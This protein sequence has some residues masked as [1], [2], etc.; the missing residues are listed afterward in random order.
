MFSGKIWRRRVCYYS[1]WNYH[2]KANQIAEQVR[3]TVEG[4]LLPH[5]LSD[6]FPY[7]TISVGLA[8]LI[9]NSQTSPEYLIANADSALYDAKMAGRNRIC[10]RPVNKEF[11]NLSS[12]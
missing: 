2:K 12:H 11:L 3:T 5:A 1:S 8:S 7:V 10:Y 4:L 9:P 6:V